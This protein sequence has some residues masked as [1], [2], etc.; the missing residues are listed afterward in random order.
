MIQSSATLNDLVRESGAP[1]PAQPDASKV[2]ET[3]RKEMKFQVPVTWRKVE[4][5]VAQEVV[6][7]F[8]MK[9]VDLCFGG[10]KKLRELQ[11]LRDGKDYSP[12]K[13]YK[14]PIVKHELSQAPEVK[15]KLRIANQVVSETTLKLKVSLK[16]EGALLHIQGGR[17][18]KV[19]SGTCQLKGSVL[20]ESAEI[21]KVETSA[22]EVGGVWDFGDGLP[23][24]E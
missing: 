4:E 22:V 24:P 15:L 12:S 6:D 1:S 16:L 13:L 19:Q 17:I 21:F 10:W 9:V 3:L 7:L 20:F 14:V 23:I 8:D 18:R 11:D 5:L 2:T